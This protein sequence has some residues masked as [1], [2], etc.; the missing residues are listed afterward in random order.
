M[1]TSQV[2]VQVLGYSTKAQTQLG[3][4]FVPFPGM[5][6]LGDQALGTRTLPAGQCIL[7]TP[8]SQLLGFLRVHWERHL[9]CSVC[10]LWRPDL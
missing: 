5:S 7:T 4:H 10:L 6:S 8:L 2:Q 1:C 9:R 3:L